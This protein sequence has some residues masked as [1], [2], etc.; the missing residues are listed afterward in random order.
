MALTRHTDPRGVAYVSTT[1]RITGPA[2]IAAAEQ[3]AAQEGQAIA[4]L[5]SRLVLEEVWYCANPG[6]RDH[7]RR[8]RAERRLRYLGQAAR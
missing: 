6:M 2:A 8:A 5:A 7:V 3:L 4:E 1:V